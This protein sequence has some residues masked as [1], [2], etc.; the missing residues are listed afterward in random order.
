MTRRTK[1]NGNLDN[2]K[3][4]SASGPPVLDFDASEFA[5][6]L[7]DTGWSDEQKAEYITLVWNIVCEF[8]ALGFNVHPVQQAKEPCG[9]L[10]ET[11][12]E[13]ALSEA[14]MIDFSHSDLIEKFMRQSGPESVSGARGVID[15]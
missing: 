13:S 10:P 9:K 2:Q 15:E 12:A 6:F 1:D 11:L 7:D 5:H 8:V 3:T 4:R 14:S